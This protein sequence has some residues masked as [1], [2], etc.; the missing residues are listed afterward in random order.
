MPNEYKRKTNRGMVPK[1]I[2]ELAAEEMRRKSLRGAAQSY[3]LNRTSLYKYI[4]KKEAFESNETA[5]PP[6]VRYHHPTVFAKDEEK[7]LCEYLLMCSDESFGL[8][9][10]EAR[11]L[12]YKLAVAYNKECPCS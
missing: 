8:S 2:Y 7:S 6:S 5:K 11:R 10:K 9:T 4:K 1:E 12:A 3:D